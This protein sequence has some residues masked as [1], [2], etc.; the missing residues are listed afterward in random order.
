[1]LLKDLDFCT[2]CQQKIPYSSRVCTSGQMR[3]PSLEQQICIPEAGE[4][5]VHLSRNTCPSAAGQKGGPCS[6]RGHRRAL[7]PSGQERRCERVERSVFQCIKSLK[8]SAR[9]TL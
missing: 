8:S 7:W 1:M 5:Y 4:R 9:R 3:G 6:W 2:G